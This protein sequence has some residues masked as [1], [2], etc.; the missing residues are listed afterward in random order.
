[1]AYR[2]FAGKRPN[3]TVT[4]YSHTFVEVSEQ[5]KPAAIPFANVSSRYEGSIAW[6]SFLYHHISTCA[7][8]PPANHF[9]HF[10]SPIASIMNIISATLLIL[11]PY[12]SALDSVN[13]GSSCNYA[14]LSKSGVTNT[15]PAFVGTSAKPVRA[16][17]AI[18]LVPTL[19]SI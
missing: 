9:N 12:V 7:F 2:F 19:P 11:L 5:S 3:Q 10:C 8:P 6:L 15:V 18:G 17:A 1:M 4:F 16:V 13:L 14:I